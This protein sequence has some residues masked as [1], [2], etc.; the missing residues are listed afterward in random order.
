MVNAW[1]RHYK[2]W[3]SKNKE[4]MKK[5]SMLKWAKEARKSYVPTGK[6][7]AAKRT[8]ARKERSRKKSRTRS[9]SRKGRSRNKSKS[10]KRARSSSHK[11]RSRRARMLSTR[12]RKRRYRSRSISKRRNKRGGMPPDSK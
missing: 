8:A 3:Q 4:F 6:K 2:E 12:A 5:N 10:D 1:I 7:E 11:G 9:A